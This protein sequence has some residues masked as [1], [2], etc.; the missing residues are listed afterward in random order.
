VIHDSPESA[1]RSGRARRREESA[2]RILEGAQRILEEG[3]MEALTMQ[4]L[5]A[6]LGFTVG[7][8]YRYFASKDE[9]VAALQRRVFD[10]LAADLAL[11]LRR[12]DELRPRPGKLASLTRVAV[13]ARTYTTLADRRPT[14]ARLLA[15]ML[16]DPRNVL[17]TELGG[18]NAKVATAVGADGVREIAA[19]QAA[20]ALDEGDPI[21][22]GLVL[23]ASLQ[24]I[25]Q[26]RKL[27]RWGIPGLSSARLADAAIRALLVGWGAEPARAREALARAAEIV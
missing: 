17:G 21:E 22:R 11:G 20:G 19:A 25:A 14:D 26:T 10:G 18:Q 12:L 6:E 4:R 8:T 27:E 13:V 2:A 7:A 16:A 15:L 1:P 23:W 9:I 3:G 5:A 24:G